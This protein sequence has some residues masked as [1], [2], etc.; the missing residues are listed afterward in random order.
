MKAK[1]SSIMNQEAV[2]SENESQEDYSNLNESSSDDQEVVFQP[3]TLNKQKGASF[4]KQISAYTNS[5]TSIYAIHRRTSH[6]LG[7]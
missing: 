7:L 2:R 5:T 6:G 3:K 1:K 4:Q